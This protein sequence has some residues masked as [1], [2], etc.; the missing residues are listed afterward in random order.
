MVRP[1]LPYQKYKTDID[2]GYET[3]THVNKKPKE[4]EKSLDTS[5][6]KG[7]NLVDAHDF[8]LDIQI[9]STIG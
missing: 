2:R 4:T 6:S 3:L 8:E 5:K 1:C 9:P 7:N